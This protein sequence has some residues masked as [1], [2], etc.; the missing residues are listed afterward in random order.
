[1]QDS[2]DNLS[3][4]LKNREDSPVFEICEGLRRRMLTL[5]LRSAEPID[6]TQVSEYF[7]VSRSPVREA[8]NLLSAER[9]VV[10]LPNREAIVAPVD[11]IGLPQFMVALDVQQRLATSLAARNRSS[12]D[13]DRFEMQSAECNEAVKGQMRTGSCKQSMSSNSRSQRPGAITATRGHTKR[14]FW[15]RG[16]ISTYILSIFSQRRAESSLMTNILT[17]LMRYAPAMS[18]RQTWVAHLHTQQIEGRILRAFRHMP[19]PKFQNSAP[20]E[21]AH[22]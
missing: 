18:K 14:F 11:L 19:D 3:N 2:P 9:L 13:L 5:E 7:G 1:M 10:S 15:K 17:S 6:E 22:G 21:K 16:E 4:V 12:A 20:S 8:I